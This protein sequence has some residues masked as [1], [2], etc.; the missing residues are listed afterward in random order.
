MLDCVRTKRT[1]ETLSL[2]SSH[3]N[4]VGHPFFLFFLIKTF[5]LHMIKNISIL[6]ML[7]VAYFFLNN[8]SLSTFSSTFTDR[9]D[10]K[11]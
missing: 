7:S 1:T 3:F 2:S 9:E 11:F 4:L 6:K 8:K 10:G 5:L